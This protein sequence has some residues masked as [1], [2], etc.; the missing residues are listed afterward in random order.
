M[1]CI[2]RVLSRFSRDLTVHRYHQD[3]PLYTFRYAS[4]RSRDCFFA[5][6][7]ASF[8]L[9]FL[10]AALPIFIEADAFR[11]MT[12]VDRKWWE[13]WSLGTEES[14]VIK[15]PRIPKI[16]E[17][18]NRVIFRMIT[19]EL[20]I[21]IIVIEIFLECME[22]PVYIRTANDTSLEHSG[23]SKEI[24]SECWSWESEPY[25][26]V[27]TKEFYKIWLHSQKKYI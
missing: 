12:S 3:S 21:V 24:K 25:V 7:S 5:I 1:I 26:L 22:L 19:D 27:Y 2:L 11:K 20:L 17:E 6:F 16:L 9:F 14:I 15:T 8:A 18:A 13:S 23:E 10:S 4:V